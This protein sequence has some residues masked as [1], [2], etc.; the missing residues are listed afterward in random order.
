M[1]DLRCPLCHHPLLQNVQGLACINRHQFDRA[2][3]GYFNLLPVQNKHSREPGDAKEQLQA[4]RQFLQAGFFHPLKKRL[5]ELLPATTATLL[6]I[7]CGEGYFTAGFSDA[8]PQAQVYGIDI[9]KAGVRLAAKAAKDKTGLLYSVASSFALPFADESMDV[10]T[11]IYAPSK[12]TELCRV[13]KPGGKLVIVTPGENHLLSL[14][15][16]IYEEVRPHSRPITPEG[17]V[18]DEH[19][20]LSGDLRIKERDMCAALLEMTP[21]AWRLAPELRASI[22]ANELR[23]TLDF[24]ISSYNKK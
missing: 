17:F 21:F 7:G 24:A 4:R 22:L 6:D 20:C 13:I 10:V 19:H 23:D 8:L 1:K 2:K 3:E 14:R 5:Q 11:R 16:R 18:L 12:D 15:T 9:A